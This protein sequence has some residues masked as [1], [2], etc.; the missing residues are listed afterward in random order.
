MA[1]VVDNLI[2]RSLNFVHCCRRPE[3]GK[4]VL[5][6]SVLLISLYWITCLGPSVIPILQLLYRHHYNHSYWYRLTSHDIILKNAL[7]DHKQPFNAPRDQQ[8]SG[9][10]IPP[11]LHKMWKNSDVRSMPQVWYRTYKNCLRLHNNTKWRI[12]LWTDVSMRE[13]VASKEYSWFLPIYDSYRYPIQRV[14]AARYFILHRY[15]GFYKDMDI[16]CSSSL[17][18]LR[19]AL[20]TYSNEISTTTHG[21]GVLVFP[22]TDPIGVS[23]DLIVSSKDNTSLKQ[24]ISNLPKHNRWYGLPYLTV[25]FST[26]PMFVSL[27]LLLQNDYDENNVILLSSDLYSKGRSFFYH[28]KGSSWHGAD[29]HLGAKLWRLSYVFI[30]ILCMLV[31]VLKELLR[32]RKAK[33]RW[34]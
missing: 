26:G 9:K 16:G 3:K 8:N 14:D 5:F 6:L 2:G 28:V 19:Q 32:R 27:Q 25:L 30:C 34:Q 1:L 13:L 4:Q 18:P 15:G 24:L 11:I 31:F 33:K 7:A 23:N 12:I 29:V 17:E 21:S 20:N 22:L 10:V